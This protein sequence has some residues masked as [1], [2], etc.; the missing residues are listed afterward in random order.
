VA[1]LEDEKGRTGRTNDDNIELETTLEQFVFNLLG[2]GVETDI[3]GS[4]NLLNFCGSHC[5]RGGWEWG[6]RKKSEVAQRSEGRK[7]GDWRDASKTKFDRVWHGHTKPKA[8]DCV[9]RVAND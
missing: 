3:G 7:N 8:G 1:C 5:E 6:E 4:T 9:S 2:N